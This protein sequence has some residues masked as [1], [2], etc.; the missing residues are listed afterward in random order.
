MLI[1]TGSLAYDYIMEFPGKF[2]DHILPEKIH[3]VNLSFIVNTFAKRRGGTAGN[4]SYPLGLL[5][6]PHILYSYAGNDFAEYKKAFEKIGINMQHVRLDKTQHTATGFA[7]TDKGHN[8]IWGYYYGAASNIPTLPLKKVAKKGDLVLI[9]PQGAAGSM[10]FVRECIDLQIDYMFDP[11]FILTQVSDTDLTLG[12]LHAAYVIGNEYEM[13]VISKRVKNWTIF[14]KE[15]IVITTRGDKGSKI[16]AQGKIYTIPLVAAKVA[17]TTGAGD[18]WRGGFLAGL[19]RNFNLQ[20]CGQMGALAASFAV[21]NYG[22]QEYTYTKKQFEIS[23]RK[24]F[25]SLIKL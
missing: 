2:G 7:M 17:E 25:G 13:E 23:Y 21:G 3:D 18:A 20:T 24:N 8:Q 6:T 22:T 10:H 4:V 5:K 11:G 1:V 9:G 19:V 12:V 16:E 14:K 15:K